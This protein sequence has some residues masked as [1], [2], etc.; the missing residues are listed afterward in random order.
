M[1]LLLLLS[2]RE[3]KSLVYAKRLQVISEVGITAEACAHVVRDL[4]C[5]AE[6]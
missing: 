1:L 4:S 3:W 6:L 5:F 2:A